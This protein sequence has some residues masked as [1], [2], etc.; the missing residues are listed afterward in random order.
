[1]KLII[2][3]SLSLI[4]VLLPISA[5]AKDCCCAGGLMKQLS[6]NQTSSELQQAAT[7]SCHDMMQQNDDHSHVKCQC[8]H[9]ATSSLPSIIT[10]NISVQLETAIILLSSNTPLLSPSIDN[11]YRPPISA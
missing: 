5:S 1:M 11:I 2:N 6:Q 10:N 7:P 8:D 3:L 9:Q 4:L